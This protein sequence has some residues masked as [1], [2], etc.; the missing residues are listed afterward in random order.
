MSSTEKAAEVDGGA[1]AASANEHTED[2]THTRTTNTLDHTKSRDVVIYPGTEIMA[3]GTCRPTA[4]FCTQPQK[5][6]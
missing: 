4:L 6:T 2:V 1:S 3:D 5:L